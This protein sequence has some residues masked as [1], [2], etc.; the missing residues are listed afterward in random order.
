MYLTEPSDFEH[1]HDAFHASPPC[2]RAPAVAASIGHHH[3]PNV[4]HRPSMEDELTIH[5]CRSIPALF[6]AVYDGHGGRT[7]ATLLRNLLH[8]LFMDELLSRE[9]KSTPRLLGSS[10]LLSPTNARVVVASSPRVK[11]D[12]CMDL[13]VL[14]VPAAFTRAYRKMDAVLKLHNCVYVGATAVTAF[15]HRAPQ[16]RIL[17]VANCGDSR[18]VLSRAGKP[19]RLTTDHRPVDAERERV[20]TSGGFVMSGRV[21]GILN[22]ARAF[23]DHCMKSVVVSTPDISE[24]LLTTMDDFL[25]L[26]CD[27]LWD[28]VD[29]ATVIELCQH[30]F[31]QGL[32]SQ[33][34]SEVLVKEALLCRSTDNISVMVVQFDMDE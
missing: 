28:F 10:G 32:S 33:Q 3:D 31:D 2:I 4:T 25:V 19:V 6:L 15:V 13:S 23:G 14:D 27:G 17:T 5:Q 7:A 21:N 12:V 1:A 29:D 9:P 26:A 18:A 24:V 22:V 16:G 34:V 30:A 8:T 11:A 20:E